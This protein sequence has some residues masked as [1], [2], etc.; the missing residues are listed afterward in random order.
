MISHLLSGVNHCK[1]FCCLGVS[2]PFDACLPMQPGCVCF[3]LLLVLSPSPVL[4]V[5]Q[6]DP[7]HAGEV[8]HEEL[9]VQGIPRPQ[10]RLQGPQA[11]GGGIAGVVR[12]VSRG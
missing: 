2:F 7:G 11:Q 1:P 6:F 12:M 3:R 4:A 8:H 9:A 10:E 5:D